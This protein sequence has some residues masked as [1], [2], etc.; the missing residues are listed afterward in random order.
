MKQARNNVQTSSL[1]ELV[2]QLGSRT[3][4]VQN[5][6]ERLN[7][8]GHS[9][10]RSTIHSVIRRGHGTAAIINALL[11]VIESEKAAQRIIQ[12]RIVALTQQ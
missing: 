12:Q 7:Q 11:E 1:H 5:T 2:R 4:I 9:Y 6:L 10:S 3:N 8:Q